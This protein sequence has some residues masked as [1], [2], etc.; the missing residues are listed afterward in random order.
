[1]IAVDVG[2]IIDGL[3]EDVV[4]EVGRGVER[5]VGEVGVEVE[6]VAGVRGVVGIIRGERLEDE[7]EEAKRGEVG[8]WVEGVAGTKRGGDEKEGE[9]TGVPPGF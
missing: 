1:M 5:A 3:V 4:G 9:K 8:A 2:V 7:G 6:V